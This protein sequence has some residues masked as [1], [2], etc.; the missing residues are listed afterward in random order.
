[1]LD[2]AVGRLCPAAHFERTTAGKPHFHLTHTACASS[3][4]LDCEMP[5]PC[6][7]RLSPL[8]LLELRGLP[9]DVNL[10]SPKSAMLYHQTGSKAG[11]P[12]ASSACRA[13][14]GKAD[15]AGPQ[16]SL[17]CVQVD[18]A[19]KDLFITASNARSDSRRINLTRSLQELRSI[20]LQLTRAS[21]SCPD[22]KHMRSSSQ[23]TKHVHN[24]SESDP[25]KKHVRSFNSIPSSRPSPDLRPR[26]DSATKAKWRDSARS[27]G[28]TA[29][30]RKQFPTTTIV[31]SDSQAHT[32]GL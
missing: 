9:R 32:S 21:K 30:N 28:A 1:M 2:H 8:D 19:E 26:T 14:E 11:T 15:N 20:R 23:E 5:L 25:A 24:S 10:L 18:D 17:S 29:R 12:E 6:L 13:I 3:I 7:S 31:G 16:E 4:I 22:T 27:P